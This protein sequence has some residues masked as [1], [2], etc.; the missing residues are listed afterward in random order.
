MLGKKDS[1]V[2]IILAL[3]IVVAL[4][5]VIV[6]ALYAGKVGEIEIQQYMPEANTVSVSGNSE[7]IVEPD[8]AELYIRIETLEDTAVESQEE[9]A[10]ITNNVIDALKKAG[11]KEKDIETSSFNLYPRHEWDPDTRKSEFVG[12]EVNHLLKVTTTKL[13]DAG[14]LLDVAVNAGANGID[15]VSFGLTKE[16]EMDVNDQA[17]RAASDNAKEK[18]ESITDNLGINLGRIVKISESN[19]Q[20]AKYDYYPRAMAGEDMEEALAPTPIQP[21]KLEIRAY[22]TIVFE[23]E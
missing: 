11:I 12:Y 7:L 19:V 2:T 23:I 10:R 13:E 22:I 8:K 5:A 9:N 21:Q 18:A 4:V 15:R 6:L 3:G 14:E 17:L 1:T 20:F 16:T